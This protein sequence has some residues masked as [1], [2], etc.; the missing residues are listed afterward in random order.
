MMEEIVHVD[1]WFFEKIKSEEK[2]FEVRLGNME[3][4]KGDV[5]VIKERGDDGKETG[6][7]LK[8]RVGFT[9]KTNNLTWWTQEEKNKH[10][11]VVMQLEKTE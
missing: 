2:N 9:L 4:N 11:F 7:E 10:G 5:L 8:K 1:N 3:I 6:R